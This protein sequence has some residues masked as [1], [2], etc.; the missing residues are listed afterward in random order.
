MLP[1]YESSSLLPFLEKLAVEIQKRDWEQFKFQAHALKGPAGY[2]GASRL[3]YSCYYIQKAYAES[4]YQTMIDFYPLVIESAIELRYHLRKVLAKYE[5]N[6]NHK[7][8]L[9]INL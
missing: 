5:G 2:I 4:D 7:P 1:A 3:H 6:G 8:R 9:T